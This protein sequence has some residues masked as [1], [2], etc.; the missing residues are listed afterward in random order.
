[1]ITSIQEPNE[2]RKRLQGFYRADEKSY[3]RR[4]IE[5]TELSA[6]S[7]NRIYNIAKQVIEKIKGNKLHVIDTIMQQYLI[8]SD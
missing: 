4:L 2:L 3:V 8:S 1:M 5:K 7:K 6:D